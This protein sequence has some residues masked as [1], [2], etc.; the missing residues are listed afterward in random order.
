MQR[1]IARSGR[2]PSAVKFQD[3]KEHARRCSG[4]LALLATAR[5]KVLGLV[6]GW[7][8]GLHGV[9]INGRFCRISIVVGT[10]CLCAPCDSGR[11]FNGV[12][13]RGAARAAAT[14]WRASRRRVLGQ[15]YVWNVMADHNDA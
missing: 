5:I 12:V 13:K 8:S 11:P 1:W 3:S 14:D 2:C 7:A 9:V 4:S 15:R 6:S 10:H